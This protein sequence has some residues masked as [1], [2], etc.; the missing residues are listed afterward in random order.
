MLLMFCRLAFRSIRLFPREG[1]AVRGEGKL[2][3][4]ENCERYIKWDDRRCYEKVI[5]I[6]YRTENSGGE[7]WT[8]LFNEI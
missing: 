6:I 1:D 3:I 2:K 4:E 8:K 5:S 7:T